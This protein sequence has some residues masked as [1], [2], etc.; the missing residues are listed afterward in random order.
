MPTSP[1]P[2]DEIMYDEVEQ[3]PHVPESTRSRSSSLETDML[4]V[5]ESTVVSDPSTDEVPNTVITSAPVS[6]AVDVSII[7]EP[8][9]RTLALALYRQRFHMQKMEFFW[10]SIQRIARDNCANNC[11]V[12]L[13]LEFEIRTCLESDSIIRNAFHGDENLEI[14]DMQEILS[15][16]RH[17]SERRIRCLNS[18]LDAVGT[19]CHRPLIGLAPGQVS[20]KMQQFVR[21]FREFQ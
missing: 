19:Y 2:S 12:C 21:I 8:T 16:L 1:V 4:R 7:S 20:R 17:S 9:R 10:N 13:E 11:A 18:L 14:A 6:E 15:S 3:E 5:S